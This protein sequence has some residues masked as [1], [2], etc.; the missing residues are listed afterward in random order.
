MVR[1]VHRTAIENAAAYDKMKGGRIMPN[2]VVAAQTSFRTSISDSWHAQI[3]PPEFAPVQ[4]E[5]FFVKIGTKR[6]GLNLCRTVYDAS[7][8]GVPMEAIAETYNLP[9]SVV[10]SIIQKGKLDKLGTW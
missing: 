10:H 9:S 5:T 2:D 4:P 3:R 6:Y 7:R 1:K 8:K